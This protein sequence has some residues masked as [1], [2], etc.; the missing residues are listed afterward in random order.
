M[1]SLM[2]I[3]LMCLISGAAVESRFSVNN[4]LERI[5]VVFTLAAA[6]LLI[7]I[8]CL[9]LVTRLGGPEG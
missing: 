5:L 6:Q 9:S 7:A 4:L 8:Q 1:I 3:Y 2:L